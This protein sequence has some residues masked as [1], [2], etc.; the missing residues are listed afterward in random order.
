MRKKLVDVWLHSLQK[1]QQTGLCYSQNIVMVHCNLRLVD[2]VE[3]IGHSDANIEWSSSDEDLDWL[4]VLNFYEL[5]RTL[6]FH[7]LLRIVTNYSNFTTMSDPKSR[8]ESAAKNWRT[9]STWHGWPVTVFRGQKSRSPG[10]ITPWPMSD[11]IFETEGWRTSNLV[12][13]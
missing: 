13:R 8:M 9:G 7:E 4:T 6:L 11:I 2:N 12:Y 5:L 3:M 1:A 10:R